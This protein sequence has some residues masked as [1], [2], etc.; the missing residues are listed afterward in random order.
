M[1]GSRGYYVRQNKLDRE[2]QAPHNFAHMW[3]ITKHMDKENNL[4]VTRG[5]EGWGWAQGVKGHIYTVA[6]KK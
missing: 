4:V 6:D 2:R 1:D 3:K 5:E